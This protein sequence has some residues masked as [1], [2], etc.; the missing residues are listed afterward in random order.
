MAMVTLKVQRIDFRQSKVVNSK[1]GTS[2]GHSKPVSSMVKQRRE[3]N[4][5]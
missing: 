4:P 3:R 5:N 2:N 1:K